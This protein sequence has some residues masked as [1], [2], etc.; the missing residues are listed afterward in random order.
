MEKLKL[1]QNIANPLHVQKRNT[2]VGTPYWL[3]PEAILDE[4]TG[5]SINRNEL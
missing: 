4:N 1:V 3:S 2:V 5:E